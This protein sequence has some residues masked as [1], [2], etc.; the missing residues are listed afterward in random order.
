MPPIRI[1]GAHFSPDTRVFIESLAAHR[2][3]YLIVGGE[4][5]ILYGHARLTGVEE[6]IASAVEEDLAAYLRRHERK[7]SGEQKGGGESG[8]GGTKVKEGVHVWQK[9][10]S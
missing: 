9:S 4:A 3:R 5:V 7:R 8:A 2:V 10:K 6:G 1:D